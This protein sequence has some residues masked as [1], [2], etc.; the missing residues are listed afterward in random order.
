M[1]VACLVMAYRAAP[2]LRRTAGVLAQAGWDVFVHL[3]RKA[4]RS[5]YVKALGQAAALCSFVE[6]PVE[7]FWGGFSGSFVP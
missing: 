5:A 7:V 6:D 1:K 4:D 2:V 3:D